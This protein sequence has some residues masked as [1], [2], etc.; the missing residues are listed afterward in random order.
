MEYTI[1]VKP[2]LKKFLPKYFNTK[3]P[4]KIDSTNVHGKVFVAVSVVQQD[5]LSKFSDQSYSDRL[6][7]DLSHELQRIRPKKRDIQK[8]NI[9]FD[10]LFKE[11]MY[12][13]ALASLMSG[14]YASEGLKNF[15]DYYRISE[16]DYSWNSA[17]R[18]WMRYYRKE[19][20][21]NCAIVS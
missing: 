10:K 17:H 2:H 14:T 8:I 12:Q 3:E 19:Y 6:V 21:K 13:W 20:E 18:A 1:Y 9:Y 7:F 11:I 4:I 16:D 15:L 5:T